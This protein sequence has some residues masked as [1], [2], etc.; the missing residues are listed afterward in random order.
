MTADGYL[1]SVIARYRVST[2]AG[3][4]AETAGN[5]IYPA[6]Q[7]WAGNQLREVRYSGSTAKGTG[8]K[9]TTDVD[10]FVS[11]K[12]DTPNTLKEIFDSLHGTMRNNGYP[13]ATKQNVS[14]HVKHK[15][16]EV[17]LVPAV[18]HGNS[19]EDHWLYV[20]KAN[21]ERTQTNV[22]THIELIR[23]S[24]CLDEI[25]LAKIWRKNHGL[26]FPS[27]YLELAV[28][29]AM[30]Y[31]TPHKENFFSMLNYLANNFASTRFIDPANTANVISDTLTLAEKN[32]IAD[33]ASRSMQERSWGSIVW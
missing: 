3:S 20:N 14:I 7:K 8:I 28:L 24:G 30:Q 10:L 13:N 12:S 5:E 11:L 17:D 15:G 18:H 16:I 31:Q 19:S 1:Q 4:P 26:D 27:F 22:N 23:K 29:D 2:G 32:A 25:I 21:R 33:Q 6:L 9:G